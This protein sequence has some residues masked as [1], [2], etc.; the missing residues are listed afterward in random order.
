M[1]SVSPAI[2]ATPVDL[3]E[4]SFDTYRS[5]PRPLPYDDP[6]FSPP[7]RDWFSLRH[8]TSSHSPEESEPLRAND[9]EEMETPS[10]IDKASKTNYSTK[11]KISSSAY[12]DKVPPREHG[13][14]FSYF[15]PS[16]EDED[17]CPT[18]LEGIIAIII[19]FFSSILDRCPIILQNATVKF[20]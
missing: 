12:G 2:E 6:R 20:S 19:I 4:S 14:Y 17:V 1:H 18:C 8:E 11:M 3:N 9:E 13:N 10:R 15:S 5:P 7:S 16:A